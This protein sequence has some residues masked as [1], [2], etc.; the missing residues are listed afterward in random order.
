MGAGGSG[1]APFA[2]RTLLIT[3]RIYLCDD[4]TPLPNISLTKY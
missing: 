4:S 2:L 1:T 3:R